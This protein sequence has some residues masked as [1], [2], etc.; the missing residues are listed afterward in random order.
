MKSLQGEKH[1]SILGE[2][3]GLMPSQQISVHCSSCQLCKIHIRDPSFTYCLTEE[4][5]M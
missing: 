2:F 5:A 1:C 3:F 4:S